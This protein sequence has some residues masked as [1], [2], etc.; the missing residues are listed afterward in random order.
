MRAPCSSIAPER[1]RH[2]SRIGTTRSNHVLAPAC[3]R[4]ARGTSR[5]QVAH[6]PSTATESARLRRSIAWLLVTVPLA[7]CA[8]VPGDVPVLEEADGSAIDGA[9]SDSTANVDTSV[10]DGFASPPEASTEAGCPTPTI[11]CGTACVDPTLD[12]LNCGGCAKRCGA[13]AVCISGSC[14]CAAPSVSCGGTSCID[15]SADPKNCG[16]CGNTC[17]DD[18]YCNGAGVC[19]CRP[20]LTSCSG[21]CANT[22]SDRAN[23]GACGNACASGQLCIAGTCQNTTSCSDGLDSC[24]GACVNK[25]TDPLNCG[26][27]GN[28]CGRDGLCVG[29]NCRNY[30]VGVGCTACPCATCAALG[31]GVACCVAMPGQ[32]SPI[33]V[34][35]GACP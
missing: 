34:E 29:G 12:P 35:G 8:E 10:T 20:G 4:V 26:G 33:C 7:S 5:L 2:R 21:G 23:C 28:T 14:A 13:G 32:K 18:E 27:C 3:S 11:V 19:H 31:S 25:K 15:N 22:N 24:S 30:A 1:G 16:S 17:A 6:L 9:L